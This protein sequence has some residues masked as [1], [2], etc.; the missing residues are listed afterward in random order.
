VLNIFDAR[1][2]GDLAYVRTPRICPSS[3]V[4]TFKVSLT[5]ADGVV[6]DDVSRM[7]CRRDLAAPRIRIRRV[8]RRRCASRALRVDVSI[9]DASP[10]KRVHVRLNRRL[11]RKTTA[12]GF[13][14]RVRL[15]GVRAG[16]HRLSVAARDVAGNRSRRSLRFRRCAAA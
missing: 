11:L 16:R 1:S 3:G 15:R 12:T 14:L 8:S 9:K 7:P 6:T 5:W 10:L 2:L 13:K 4:W